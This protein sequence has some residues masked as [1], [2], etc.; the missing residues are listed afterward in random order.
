MEQ[1]RGCL[2]GWRNYAIS[3][4]E[5]FWC[6]FQYNDLNFDVNIMN[7]QGYGSRKLIMKKLEQEIDA[8]FSDAIKAR[9]FP[10]ASFDFFHN[11]REV[12]RKSSGHL[13]Y[14]KEGNTVTPQ[15]LF[16][17]ASV[18]KIVVAT[19]FL[20]L[21]DDVNIILS[22]HIPDLLTKLNAPVFSNITL[23]HLLTHTSGIRIRLSTL[24]KGELS[25][26][27]EDTILKKAEFET[28]GTRVE[29]ANIN[30]FIMGKII[31]Q[32]SKESLD[33]YL[34]KNVFKPLEMQHT[35]YTPSRDA[36]EN[37]APTEETDD[38]LV[39]KGIVHDESCRGL[40]GVCGHAGLFSTTDDLE[41][42]MSMWVSGGVYKNKRYISH[43]IVELATKN[44]TPSLNMPIGLGWH[45]DTSRHLGDRMPQGTFFHPGFTGTLV[46]GSIRDNFYFVLLSNSVYPIRKDPEMKNAF[47]RKLFATLFSEYPP[48]QK[49]NK[50]LA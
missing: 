33:V 8:L 21:I 26:L 49:N 4:G 1:K 16:D 17:I 13:T 2:V 24:S 5:I 7:S 11:G 27:L 36:K 35:F 30:T 19:G 20:K 18:T 41:S 6:A 43:E 45:L 31:E 42:F 23:W 15:T 12:Y 32:I 14:E 22:T 39:L 40:G 48:T 37:I 28:P 10:G 47:F 25:V 34:D 3:I 9:I 50:Y 46:G 38:G 44:Q 29:Y